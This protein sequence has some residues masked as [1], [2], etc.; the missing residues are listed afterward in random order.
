MKKIY[1]VYVEWYSADQ[2]DF[3]NTQHS[4]YLVTENRKEAE[5]EYEKLKKNDRSWSF[6]CERAVLAE[7]KEGEILT[8]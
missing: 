7:W 1:V 6:G 2:G 5:E 8:L 3:P 4:L